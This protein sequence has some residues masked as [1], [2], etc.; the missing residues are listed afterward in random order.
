M[1]NR[2]L[3]AIDESGLNRKIIE[4]AIDIAQHKHAHITLVNVNKENVTTGMMYVPEGY[5]ESMLEGLEK[6]SVEI[7][8]K[9][10]NELSAALPEEAAIE[11]VHLKGD[12][13]LQILEYA[14][15]N[16]QELIIIGSRGLSGMKGVM[17]GSV[18]LKVSQLAPCPVLIVH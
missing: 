16:G 18:S 11:A 8:E 2:I 10:K 9:A 1:F 5:L 17:L 7:V 14:K 12:P 4:A 13:A 3:V 15:E 6:E